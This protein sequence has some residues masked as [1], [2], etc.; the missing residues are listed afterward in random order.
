MFIQ[1]NQAVG[2]VKLIINISIIVSTFCATKRFMKS[3][4]NII[5]AWMLISFFV[6]TFIAGFMRLSVYMSV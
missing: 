5:L 6:W 4:K 2:I 3:D 1:N